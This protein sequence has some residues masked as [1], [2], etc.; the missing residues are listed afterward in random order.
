MNV[1]INSW[2]FT[3]KGHFLWFSNFGIVIVILKKS[4]E[5]RGRK[6]KDKKFEEKKRVLCGEN[7]IEIVWAWMLER[8]SIWAWNLK[9]LGDFG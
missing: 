9:F 8:S 4:K 2:I 1:F 7:E 3:T 5:M 6:K